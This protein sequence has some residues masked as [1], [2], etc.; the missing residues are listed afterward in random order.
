MTDISNKVRPQEMVGLFAS[1]VFLSE[2]T[3]TRILDNAVNSI[4]ELKKEKKGIDRYGSW[5]SPDNLH[6]LPEFK[7]LTDI[8]LYQSE[9]VLDVLTIKRDSHYITCMWSNIA[10]VG[11]AH[12]EHIHANSLY[13]G[14]LHLQS[15]KGS[16]PTI[17]SDP[18]PAAG[19]LHP[20]YE[21]PNPAFLG[22]RWS[23]FNKRGLLIIFPSWLPHCVEPV[24]PSVEERITLSFNIMIKTKVDFFTAKINFN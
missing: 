24:P 17:F 7:G 5:V 23:T 19:I 3:D 13:S 4:L 8:L 20:D 2:I 16:S 15:P 11:T 12:M 21:N 22:A 18:R 9:K 6:T 10:P 14:V 1:P